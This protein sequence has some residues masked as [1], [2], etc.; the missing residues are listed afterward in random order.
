MEER[1]VEVDHSTLYRWDQNYA[2]EL[3]KVL[4]SKT[5]C[6]PQHVCW[7]SNGTELQSHRI[8]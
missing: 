8:E 4:D 3:E 1:G 7:E 2:S 6:N 5:K